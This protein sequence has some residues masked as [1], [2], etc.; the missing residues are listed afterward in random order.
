[1][2][3][4][5]DAA[6]AHVDPELFHHEFCEND[7]SVRIRAALSVCENCPVTR[8]CLDWALETGDIWAVLGGTTPTMRGVSR[9]LRAFRPTKRPA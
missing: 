4:R 1:M 5:D 6:C 7:H 3:W 2:N 9:H 8:E